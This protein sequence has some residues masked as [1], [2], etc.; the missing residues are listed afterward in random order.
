MAEANLLL[1]WLEL[2]GTSLDSAGYEYRIQTEGQSKTCTAVDLDGRRVV[3]TICYWPPDT[4]EFY[5]IEPD[6]GSVVVLETRKFSD[7][8]K[9]RAYLEDLLAGIDLRATT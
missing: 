1:D 7:V 5:F 3:G 9:L 2:V 4:F 8:A 6:S